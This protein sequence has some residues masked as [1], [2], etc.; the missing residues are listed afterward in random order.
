MQKHAPETRLT[1]YK[2]YHDHKC[3]GEALLNAARENHFGFG[4][5]NSVPIQ[6]VL[7]QLGIALTMTRDQITI[8]LSQLVNQHPT[9]ISYLNDSYNDAQSTRAQLRCITDLTICYTEQDIPEGNP[10][11]IAEVFA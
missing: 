4:H 8:C 2:T 6:E 11:E 3:F 1:L 10:I 7:W 5:I 9:L